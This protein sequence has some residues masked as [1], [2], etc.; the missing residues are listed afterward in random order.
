[1]VAGPREQLWVRQEVK[2]F[3]TRDTLLT[4]L[5]VWRVASEGSSWHIDASVYHRNGLD[6]F[7]DKHKI[8]WDGMTLVIPDGDGIHFIRLS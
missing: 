5:R 8:V 2:A 1:M 4:F 3:F 7:P 6:W